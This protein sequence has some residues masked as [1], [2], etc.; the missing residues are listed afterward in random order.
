MT[1]L[2]GASVH[3]EGFVFASWRA[4]KVGKSARSGGNLLTGEPIE[5]PLQNTERLVKT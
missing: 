1:L 3:G 5:L 4:G 2:V